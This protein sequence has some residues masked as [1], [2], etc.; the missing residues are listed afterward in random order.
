MTSLVAMTEVGVLVELVRAVM[1]QM[2]KT[3]HMDAEMEAAEPLEAT[4]Q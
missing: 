3:T 4:G 1:R 2:A